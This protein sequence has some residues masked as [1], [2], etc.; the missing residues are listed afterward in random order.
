MAAIVSCLFHMLLGGWSVIVVFTGHPHLLSDKTM[1]YVQ[2][3][4]NQLRECRLTLGRP[5]DNNPL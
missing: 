1:R 3:S 2:V 4:E 5:L